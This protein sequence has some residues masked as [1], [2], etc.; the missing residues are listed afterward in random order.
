MS[1]RDTGGPAFP[2][3]DCSQ[4]L[5]TGETTAH[6]AVWSGVTVRDY[7]AA[8]ALPAIVAKLQSA[9]VPDFDELFAV[10]A[11]MA[12]SQADAMLAERA[13]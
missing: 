3:I 11:V 2:V 5:T 12:Y 8:A 10:H 1:A 9:G 4:N 13:K 7:F 6:Q